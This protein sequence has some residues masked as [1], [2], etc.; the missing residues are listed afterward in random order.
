M[1]QR[2]V[3]QQR[4][5]CKTYKATSVFRRQ[6]LFAHLTGISLSLILEIKAG[7]HSIRNRAKN[8]KIL[9]SNEPYLIGLI[10]RFNEIMLFA[11]F[12]SFVR[13]LERFLCVFKYSILIG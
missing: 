3:K 8:R 2:I 5:S 12:P 9:S 13:K 6:R 11:L 1:H 7:H 10:N 4:I